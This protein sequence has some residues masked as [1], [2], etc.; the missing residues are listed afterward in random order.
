MP[1][2]EK[3]LFRSFQYLFSLKKL[4]SGRPD[5][6]QAVVFQVGLQPVLG[7]FSYVGARV[8]YFVAQL[9]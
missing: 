6:L 4:Q 3:I 8:W 7:D 2:N 1:V 9:S 5:F